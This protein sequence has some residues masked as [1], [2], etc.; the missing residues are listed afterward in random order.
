[1]RD[2][3]QKV[4]EAREHLIEASKLLTEIIE[5]GGN[6]EASVES[7]MKDRIELWCRIY[8]EGGLVTNDR[9]HEI[10]KSMGKDTRGLG[11]YFTG[12]NSSLQYT[13]DGKVM[14]TRNAAESV[15][16]WTGKT[17]GEHAKKY[18]KRD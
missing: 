17:I 8:T 18:R 16:A 4:E 1:M 6:S 14:L 11:G 10:W 7:W 9:L 13:H 12:K 2:M 3:E 5:K 15:E